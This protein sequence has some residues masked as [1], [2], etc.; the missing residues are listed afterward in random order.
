[1]NSQLREAEQ[2]LLSLNAAWKYLGLYSPTHPASAAAFKN[3]TT[4]FEKLL[5]ERE[6]ITLGL[7]HETLVLNGVPLTAKPDLF[8]NLVTRLRNGEIHGIALLKGCT[9]EELRHLV[10]LLGQNVKRGELE[11]ELKKRQVSHI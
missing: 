1:M 6:R 2:F 5:G 8:R 3:L 11:E 4:A 10:E 7:M 9:L